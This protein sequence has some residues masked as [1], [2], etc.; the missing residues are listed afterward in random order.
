MDVVVGAAE[1]VIVIQTEDGPD[2]E[3]SKKKKKRV[4]PSN[5]MSGESRLG[6]MQCTYLE[7]IWRRIIKKE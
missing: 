6:M 3:K 5:A 2:G 1:R 4:V 7:Q